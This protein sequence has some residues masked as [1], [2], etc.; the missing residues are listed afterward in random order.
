MR[1]LVAAL[2]L[3]GGA[4]FSLLPASTGAQVIRSTPMHS[5]ALDLFP[6]LLAADPTLSH[7]FVL[8]T[9]NSI[10][11]LRMYDVRTGTFLQATSLPQLGPAAPAA[12][13]VSVRAH[14]LYVSTLGGAVPALA[15]VDTVTGRLLQV[16]VTAA[17]PTLAPGT[18]MSVGPD[19]V[20]VDDHTQR[21]FVLNRYATGPRLTHVATSIRVLTLNGALVATYALPHGVIPAVAAVDAQHGRLF[22]GAVGSNTVEVRDTV[23]GGPVASV[24]VSPNPCALAIDPLAATMLVAG[25]A[26]PAGVTLVDARTGALVSRAGASQVG[27]RCQLAVDAALHRAYLLRQ[28]GRLIVLDTR[29]GALLDSLPTDPSAVALVVD[30]RRQRVLSANRG[31][32]AVGATGMTST[33]AGSV[34]IVDER[35]LTH[36]QTYQLPG[37]P[38]LMWEDTVTGTVYFASPTG[39][40]SAGTVTGADHP[41][42]LVMYQRLVA[43]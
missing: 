43:R 8:G 31:S 16:E 5:S 27:Y 23:S 30:T 19:G 4:A 1:R 32:M 28:D 3:A 41:G 40:Q 7:L 11:V 24:A 12:A 34:T 10:P 42:L 13:A 33:R 21:V 25:S 29:S 35:A 14:R 9:S 22:V 18:S 15:I 39:S 2:L 37:N 6:A 17:V 20:A 38:T 26:S 36:R